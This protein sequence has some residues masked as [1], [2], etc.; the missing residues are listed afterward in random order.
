MLLDLGFGGAISNEQLL[1]ESMTKRSL[2]DMD[3]L[4]SIEM[5]YA[6]NFKDIILSQELG[7]GTFG[8]VFK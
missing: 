2:K 4:W 1:N 3:E 7:R 8:I 6:I 5:D